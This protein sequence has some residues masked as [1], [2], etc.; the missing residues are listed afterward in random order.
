MQKSSKSIFVMLLVL[1]LALV[2]QTEKKGR[3]YFNFGV[4]SM[5]GIYLK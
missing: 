2:S 4:F 5:E 3:A 1:T